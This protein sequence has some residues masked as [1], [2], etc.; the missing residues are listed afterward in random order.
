[1]IHY[2][3]LLLAFFS[4]NR[5][6]VERQVII[7]KSKQEVF[8]Y[9]VMLKNQDNYS[10]WANKDAKMKKWYKGQD[11]K[12]GFVSAW[13]SADDEI[14]AGEQEIIRITG[15]QQIDYELRFKKPFEATEPAYM[16]LTEISANQTNLKWGFKGE[17]DFP[18][19]IFLLFMDMEKE[20][21]TDLDNGLKNLKVILEK[22]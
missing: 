7:N 9:V 16:L 20:I 10:V 12:E 3:F 15:N 17:M 18:F 8:D 6:H 21:G 2:T 19:N 22:N 11:G 5:Y 13:E 4:P 1:L 14:G